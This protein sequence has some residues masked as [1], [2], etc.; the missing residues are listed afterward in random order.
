[1]CLTHNNCHS[2]LPQIQIIPIQ[3][4]CVSHNKYGMDEHIA[5][6]TW[7]AIQWYKIKSQGKWSFAYGTCDTEHTSCSNGCENYFPAICLYN[8]KM[9]ICKGNR[10]ANILCKGE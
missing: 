2:D 5:P 7:N 9:F 4:P 10:D 1:M 8:T 6:T 3:I